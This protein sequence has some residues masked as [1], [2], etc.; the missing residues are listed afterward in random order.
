MLAGVGQAPAADIYAGES[1]KDAP[2]TY[3]SIT[4]TG[5][6]LGIH[7]GYAD[8]GWDGRLGFDD[9]N[10][11]GPD[12]AGYADPTRDLGADGWL[13]GAQIGYNKQR[14]SLVFGIEADISGTDFEGSE[15]FTTDDGNFAKKHEF[16]LDY[17]GTVRGRLGYATGRFMPYITGGLAFGST[18]G[19]L[20][21]TYP[22]PA[23]NLL[24]QSSNA[25]VEED[26]FG[27]TIGAG[28]EAMVGGGWSLKAEYLY[29]DLGEE[30][31]RF[32]GTVLGDPA[33]PFDTDSFKSELDFD[34]FR[35]GLN[36][37]FGARESEPLK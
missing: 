11:P 24:G 10:T 4:W 14:G 31:Y 27:Y 34:V 16:Q 28:V 26:H 1:M 5:F 9:P 8:G 22:N 7:G 32:K 3:N 21:V 29:V 36:Y 2:A 18:K 19:D 23:F 12:D 13:G 30:D 25:S 33:R 20:T 15:T 17:F 6:Y 35:V 37:K